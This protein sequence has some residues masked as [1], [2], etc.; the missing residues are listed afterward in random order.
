VRR[1]IAVNTVGCTPNA[2]IESEISEFR[3]EVNNRNNESTRSSLFETNGDYK[4]MRF[5]SGLKYALM[6]PSHSYAKNLSTWNVSTRPNTYYP[7]VL[8]PR[9][10]L[11]PKEAKAAAATLVTVKKANLCQSPWKMN[12][13]VKLVRF[14]HG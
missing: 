14:V 1:R 8:P 12:F 9:P 10:P 5:G 7:R 4:M 3:N 13:L 6:S 2:Q 11:E